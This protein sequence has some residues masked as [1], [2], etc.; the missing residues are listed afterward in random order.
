M[1][2][3]TA[4]RTIKTPISTVVP[5]PGKTLPASELR[6]LNKEP[7]GVTIPGSCEASEETALALEEVPVAI[8]KKDLIFFT[9]CNTLKIG[10]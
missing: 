2:K 10:E 4:K 9:F 5:Q 8:I 7:K 6:G 1:T 3:N